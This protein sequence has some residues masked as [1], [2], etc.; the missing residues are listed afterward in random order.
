M[1]AACRSEE[2]LSNFRNAI[3]KK[4]IDEKVLPRKRFRPYYWGTQTSRAAKLFANKARW[5]FCQKQG[6]VSFS[7]KPRLRVLEIERKSLFKEARQ[8]CIP[9]L[10]YKRLFF[11]LCERHRRE[12]RKESAFWTTFLKNATKKSFQAATGCFRSCSSCNLSRETEFS[13]V[14]LVGFLSNTNSS[15][16]KCRNR[17][18]IRSAVF[19]NEKKQST[20]LEGPSL[21]Q[22]HNPASRHPYGHVIACILALSIRKRNIVF[23]HEHRTRAR[24]KLGL[25]WWYLETAL[26]TELSREYLSPQSSR[27]QISRKADFSTSKASGKTFRKFR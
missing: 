4:K 20:S 18:R 13:Q 5:Y 17:A 25:F 16:W 7:A 23:P 14:R 10:Q 11:L 27:R 1:S 15:S 19:E 21:K 24:K 12:R 6:Q 26:N 22:T 8:N 9:A 3:P 2:N